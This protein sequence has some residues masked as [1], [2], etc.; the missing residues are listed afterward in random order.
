MYAMMCTRPNLA[1]AVSVLSRFV[2]PGRHGAP[3]WAA[4][5]RVLRYLRGTSD[6]ALTLGGPAV[7]QLLGFSDAS[8]ADCQP[9]RRSTQ[10]YT[11]SLGS[12]SIS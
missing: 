7:P 3:H 1:Y 8:W 6:L 9:D 4:A 2:G 12:G 5:Q 10:G 11:F